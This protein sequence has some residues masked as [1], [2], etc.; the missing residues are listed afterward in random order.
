MDQ[1]MA[2]SFLQEH[3][4]ILW[5]H[6]KEAKEKGLHD[7]VFLWLVENDE[8]KQEGRLMARFEPRASIYDEMK[9]SDAVPEYTKKQLSAPAGPGMAWMILATPTGIASMRISYAL[10]APGG[11]A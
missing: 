9:D 6:W 7:L 11:H 5:E 2:M 1:Q 3:S 8:E 10:A 4:E